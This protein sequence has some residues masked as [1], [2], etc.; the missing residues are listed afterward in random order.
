MNSQAVE[1]AVPERLGT[2]RKRREMPPAPFLKAGVVGNST[3]KQSV[4]LQFCVSFNGG[5]QGGK[6]WLWAEHSLVLE[7]ENITLSITQAWQT[8]RTSCATGSASYMHPL[9]AFGASCSFSIAVPDSKLTAPVT[10][11]IHFFH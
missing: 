10:Q 4:T 11:Q 7:C 5:P 3:K 8:R 2:R 9:F 6:G 1:M